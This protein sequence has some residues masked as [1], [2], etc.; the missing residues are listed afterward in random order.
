[1]SFVI[2]HLADHDHHSHGSSSQS[3]FHSWLHASLDLSAEQEKLLE[4]IESAFEEEQTKARE[5][6]EHQ[7]AALATAIN[8][9][10]TF[11]EEL[12][13]ALTALQESQAA[14]QR[15]TLEHFFA[16]KEH[17]NDEQAAQL[18]QWTHDSIIGEHQH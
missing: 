3:D 15:L 16:M 9:S 6:I 8:D 2:V 14:L 12:T 1:M 13:S 7:S 10:N 18:R 5:S 17:L 11:G 4:P